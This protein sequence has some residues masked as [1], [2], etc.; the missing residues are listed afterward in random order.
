MMLFYSKSCDKCHDYLCMLSRCY[1]LIKCDIRN[2][3]WN[4]LIMTHYNLRRDFPKV[5]IPGNADV[6]N[7]QKL[8]NIIFYFQMICNYQI[9]YTVRLLVIEMN[10]KFS[11]PHFV[12]S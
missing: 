1:I 9:C 2:H 8:N 5:L 6:P 10:T 12:I 4:N 3:F 11:N 7:A